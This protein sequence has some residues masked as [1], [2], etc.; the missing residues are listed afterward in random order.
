MSN[1]DRL[2]YRLQAETSDARA[3]ARDTL[4]APCPTF[5]ARWQRVHIAKWL[6]RLDPQRLAVGAA[7]QE[8]GA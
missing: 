5:A 1:I 7:L 6:C 4:A 3:A 2:R 8:M